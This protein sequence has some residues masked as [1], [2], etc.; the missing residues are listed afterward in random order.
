MAKK[1]FTQAELDAFEQAKKSIQ[2]LEKKY[3]GK[4]A[5]Q[6]DR[7]SIAA[8]ARVSAPGYT[9]HLSE[10]TTE[11]QNQPEYLEHMSKQRLDAM[12]KIKPGSEHTLREILTEA[13]RKSASNPIHH[14]NRK[15]ANAKLHNDPNWQ[16]AHAAGV[17]AYSEAVMTPHGEYSSIALWMDTCG[18]PGGRSFIKSLP[19]LFYKIETGPGLPTYERIYVTPYGKCA[20]TTN[21]YNLSKQSSEVNAIKL[22]NIDGWWLKMAALYPDQYY[23]NIDQ[24]KYWAIENDI[25]YGMLDDHK[26]PRIQ[27]TDVVNQIEK[28]NKRLDYHRTLYKSKVKE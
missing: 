27:S 9:K 7:K 23:M 15:A 4:K 11:R 2:S 26:K 20:T 12:D 5:N 22:R 10:T 19:H 6:S 18:T 8:R 3:E 13:N 28:W 24:A 17:L 16:E 21:A 1:K 25:P 14:A